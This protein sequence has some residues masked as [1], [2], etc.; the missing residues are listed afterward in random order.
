MWQP[1]LSRYIVLDMHAVQAEYL[2]V[3]RQVVH[4]AHEKSFRELQYVV[5]YPLI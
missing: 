1:L 4:Y 5:H 3:H 2:L